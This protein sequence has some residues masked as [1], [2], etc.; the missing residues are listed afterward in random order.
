MSVH[1]AAALNLDGYTDLP[2]TRSRR[3]SPIS[4]C[5][6]ARPCPRSGAAGLDAPAHRSGP[7]ALPGAVPMVGEPWLWFSRAVM[8]DDE[9][10]EILGDP[11]VE[12]YALNDGSADVG[13][14]E[15]DFRP[16]GEVELAFSASFRLHRAGGGTLPDERSH[17]PRLRQAD[18]AL[19]RPYLHARCP[20]RPRLLSPLGLHALSARH[21]GGGRSPPAR[22][23]AAGRGAP[24]SGPRTPDAKRT[25]PADAPFQ[26]SRVRRIRPSRAPGVRARSG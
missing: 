17:R 23:S 4:R 18:P 25:R 3:S 10:A 6:N 2:R 26:I 13:L 19:L 24:R 9:L 5:G 20:G 8:A 7:R 21:R 15:L 11:E 14:L 12:A 22:I 1:A 16:E